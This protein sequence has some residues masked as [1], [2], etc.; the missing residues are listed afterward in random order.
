MAKIILNYQCQGILADSRLYI[1]NNT[2]VQKNHYFRLSRH[3][4]V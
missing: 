3:I 4:T 1:L 2:Y